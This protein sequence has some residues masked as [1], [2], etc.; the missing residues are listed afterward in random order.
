MSADKLIQN[1]CMLKMLRDDPRFAI[2]VFRQFTHS[3]A[4]FMQPLCCPCIPP[5]GAAW[6]PAQVA[7]RILALEQQPEINATV[8]LGS[9]C[10]RPAAAH[11]FTLMMLQ[12]PVSGLTSMVQ[13]RSILRSFMHALEDLP[14]ALSTVHAQ[15]G[16]MSACMHP[17]FAVGYRYSGGAEINV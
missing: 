11:A 6:S 15:Y 8:R 13:A 10:A 17:D 7:S 2:L 12:G 1:E 4:A 14:P 5:P 16:C 3:Y 9:L